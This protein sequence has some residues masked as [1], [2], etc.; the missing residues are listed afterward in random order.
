MTLGES[1]LFAV[2]LKRGQLMTG[3]APPARPPAPRP[4]EDPHREDLD[5]KRRFKLQ[6]DPLP[7]S[8]LHFGL[9]VHG[10]ISSPFGDRLHPILH[11]VRPHTGVDIAAAAGTPI[12]APASGRVISAGWRG[13]YG[14]AVVVDH[15]NGDS[16]LYGHMS[17]IS[18]GV[19]DQVESGAVLGRVGQTGRATGP[20][21]HF[22]TRH[23]GVPVDPLGR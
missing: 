14:L 8:G 17:S 18:V 23:D 19:G 21:V 16:T 22:E 20:H 3:W 2:Q 4:R 5:D 9:P 10:R 7:E 1:L 13:G 11:Q 6:P 12:L 15:G